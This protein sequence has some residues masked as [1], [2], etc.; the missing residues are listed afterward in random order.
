MQTFP[1]GPL[2]VIA[3]AD[4]NG[5]NIY[6]IGYKYYQNKFLCFIGSEWTGATR[7]E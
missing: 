5:K 6:V 3:S 7:S 2:F 4:E 1:G